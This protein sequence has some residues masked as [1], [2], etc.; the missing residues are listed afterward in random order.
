MKDVAFIQTLAQ[1]QQNFFALTEVM[2]NQEMTL[3]YINKI[4]N[5]NDAK[6]IIHK[7]LINIL[8]SFIVFKGRQCQGFNMPRIVASTCLF[9]IF[10]NLINIFIFRM[11]GSKIVT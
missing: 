7:K 2:K 11:I 6:D 8:D 4:N 1:V 9:K 5:S 10:Y 3:H